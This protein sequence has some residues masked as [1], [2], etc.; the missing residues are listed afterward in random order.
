[1]K[2]GKIL[3][4]FAASPGLAL[5]R[6][7]NVRD[8]ESALLAEAKPGEII[9]T[10][11]LDLSDYERFIDKAAAFVSDESSFFLKFYAKE[12]GKPAVLG[13]LGKGYV[14]TQVLD[15]GQKIIVDG[16]KGAVYKCPQPRRRMKMD[17]PPISFTVQE[18]NTSK[19]QTPRWKG[20]GTEK[21][22]LSCV[23]AVNGYFV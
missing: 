7:R 11:R 19:L 1:M 20:V 23:R 6:V 22:Q 3:E 21:C 8:S 12:Y 5:G 17:S 18:P 9:V 15:T 14:A 13:T 4:G 16:F 2:G 10:K